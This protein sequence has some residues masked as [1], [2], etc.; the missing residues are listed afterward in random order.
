VDTWTTTVPLLTGLNH[1]NVQ[2]YVFEGKLVGSQEIDVTSTADVVPPADSLKVTELMFDPPA[3]PPGSAFTNNDDY[4]FIE[5]KNFGSA[6]IDLS[7]VHFTDAIDFTFR[8]VTLNPGEVGVVVKNVD[9]FQSRYGTAIRILGSYESSTKRFANNA[10]HVG[11]ADANGITIA[12]F[13]YG[14]DPAQGWYP[15][16]VGQGSSLVV[17]NPSVNSDLSDPKS[18]RPSRFL[19]GSPGVDETIPHVTGLLLGSSTV[20]NGGYVIPP[21]AVQSTPLAYANLDQIKIT[22]DQDVVVHTGDLSLAGVN[23]PGYSI[24]GFRYDPASFTA[25]WTLAAPIG[26]DR[27]RL[28]LSDAVTASSGGAALDGEWAD[29]TS[30]F[31]S[32]DSLAGGDF[33]FRFNVL[34][35]DADGSGMVSFSDLL[36]LAQHY[37]Q[38]ATSAAQGDFNGD[39]VV[40]F[41]DLLVLAQHYGSSLPPMP[42][43]F[44]PA[45]LTDPRRS[46]GQS[47]PRLLM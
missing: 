21:G 28:D 40:N 38:P 7:G 20:N 13:T 16:T 34:P 36:I 31:P 29:G 10:E 32:G 35:G 17:V 42:A 23:V 45:L 43:P 27:L 15:S 12:D 41:A 39:A 6:P 4:E 44:A 2:A 30:M 18:W 46:R 8:D 22:F 24:T 25:T 19:D 9:A 3:P 11:I 5:F 14:V 47:R 26:D 1:L 33:V 37:G